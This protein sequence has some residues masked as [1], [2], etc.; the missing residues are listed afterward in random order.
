MTAT[1]NL[2]EDHL[3]DTQGEVDETCDL[4]PQAIHQAQDQ[5]QRLLSDGD[6]GL[7]MLYLVKL[8]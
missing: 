4:V 8:G 5:A 6:D 3:G 7:I 2:S 1:H